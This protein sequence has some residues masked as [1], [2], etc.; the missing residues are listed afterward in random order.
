MT[1]LN[2]HRRTVPFISSIR[3]FVLKRS[4]HA[5]QRGAGR[6]N[7]VA[8]RPTM[9]HVRNVCAIDLVVVVISRQ[10]RAVHDAK[11][12]YTDERKKE[13][14]VKVKLFFLFHFFLF[15]RSQM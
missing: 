8:N 2:H 13:S 10:I 6:R 12:V 4:F 1:L 5:R 7:T 11:L 9:Q 14:A 3:W 15:V